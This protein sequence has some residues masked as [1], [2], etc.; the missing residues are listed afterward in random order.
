VNG[1]VSR[2]D[3]ATNTRTIVARK[4]KRPEGI[5]LAAD[6][7]LIVA[8][9]GTKRVVAIDP[10]GKAKMEVLAD[11]LSIGLNVGNKVPAPFLPTGVTVTKDGAIYVTG[12]IYNTLYRIAKR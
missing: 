4:L 12:D 9:V 6:G 3:L 7:R 2:I 11:G 5:A 10:S 1:D 8:E